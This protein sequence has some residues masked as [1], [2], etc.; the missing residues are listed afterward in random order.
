[1]EQ[2][3]PPAVPP[4]AQVPEESPEQLYQRALDEIR[5]EKQFSEGRQL[6]EKFTSTYPKHDLYVNAL[7]WT[8]EARYGGTKYKQAIL[9][10]Q[11]VIS[12]YKAYPKA[13]AAILKQA[14][15]FN[16]LGDEQNVP[17]QHAETN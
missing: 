14:L 7:Y 10:F 8:G 12:K 16:A 11:D 9:P 5:K 17:H 13:P 2:A 4:E 1:M 3:P 6:L 15:A